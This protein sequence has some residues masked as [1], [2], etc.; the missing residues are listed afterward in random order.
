MGM[1][2][3]IDVYGQSGIEATVRDV[4]AW[5]HH[6]DRTF[7]PYKPGSDITRLGLG[8]ISLDDADCDVVEVL[9]ECERVRAVTSGAFD[10][11]AV[12]APN[13]SML[14]PSGY[15]KGWA[16][17]RAADMMTAVGVENFCINAGGDIALH[18]R[19]SPEPSWR[20][21]IRDPAHE[22]G[23]VGVIDAVGAVAIAT[24]G[25]YERGAHIVD[26]RTAEPAMGVSSV[27]IVGG[28]LAIADAYATA[29]FVMGRDGLDWLADQPGY[30]AVVV[31]PDGSIDVSAP[32][33]RG[34]WSFRE[35]R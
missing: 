35:I 34:S 17:Q 1:A 27:T 19:P 21:G 16:V 23:M 22:Q 18:G 11:F 29:V 5:L 9:A 31:S 6:V 30:D 32:S 10:V 4:V 24:S 25:T 7:S 3:S 14:D 33:G 2:V 28:D 8:E 12:P 20:I 13:G 26:P 15:V